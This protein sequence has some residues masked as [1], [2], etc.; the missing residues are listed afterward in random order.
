MKCKCR[1]NKYLRIYHFFPT[2]NR[3]ILHKNVFVEAQYYFL[4][5][6]NNILYSSSVIDSPFYMGDGCTV[7][8]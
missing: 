4:I 5:L 2:Y 3:N 6:E 8:F 7:E 1:E